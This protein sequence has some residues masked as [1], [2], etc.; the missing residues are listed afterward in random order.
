M[1]CNIILTAAHLELAGVRVQRVV[2]EHHAAGDR[3]ADP[4][5]HNLILECGVSFHWGRVFY[6][7]RWQ[8]G[9]TE[10]IIISGEEGQRSRKYSSLE[11]WRSWR[12]LASGHRGDRSDRHQAARFFSC[13]LRF[14]VLFLHSLVNSFSRAFSQKHKSKEKQF[15]GKVVE[16]EGN[17]PIIDLRAQGCFY[18]KGWKLIQDTQYSMS[19]SF[20]VLLLVKFYDYQDS[21][22]LCNPWLQK[23]L[24]RSHYGLYTASVVKS[25]VA[26]K[27]GVLNILRHLV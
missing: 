3:D 20:K 14:V 23:V 13:G 16:Q 21:S 22:L 1:C 12:E 24:K 5:T 25:E 6:I 19:P 11:A 15:L 8:A 26:C 7:R 18:F 4:E 9:K 10:E 2:V 27:I 17:G